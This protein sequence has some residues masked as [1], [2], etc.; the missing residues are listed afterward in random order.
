GRY[1]RSPKDSRRNGAAEPQR[2]TVPVK[3]STSNALVS[4]YDGVGSYDWSYQEEEEP[5]NYALMA[6]S[7]SS[8]SSDNELSPTKPEQDLS[9]TN[10]PTAPI[11]E[12]WVSDSKDESETKAP[13]ILTQSKQLSITA[14]RPV[15]TAVPQFK[16]TRPRHAKPIVTKTNSPIRRHI[17]R[18]HSPKTSNSPP[19]VTAIKAPV[20]N[21]QHALKDKGV[22]DS[23]CSRHMTGNM[24]YLSDFEELNGEY[25]TFGG[26]PKGGKISRKG[27]IRT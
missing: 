24:S 22:I 14:V 23:G 27:K 19:R 15:S 13:Q 26:N 12:D 16:V 9:Y 3:T 4:Q 1:S 20:G 25:V 18:S 17:T 7:S 10:R 6:F 5:V 8:S 21:P 11:I 2:K